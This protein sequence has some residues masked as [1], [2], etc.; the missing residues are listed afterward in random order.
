MVHGE[1]SPCTML[2]LLRQVTEVCAQNMMKKM[3]TYDS[4]ARTPNKQCH[5][6]TSSS[7][8]SDS[9]S[10][11]LHAPGGPCVPIREQ[12]P[13]SNQP[14]GNLSRTHNNL[15]CLHFWGIYTHTHTHMHVVVHQSKA[16]WSPP[17]CLL[18][19][20]WFATESVIWSKCGAWHGRCCLVESESSKSC[21]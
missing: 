13:E 10:P 16:P 17:P 6:P 7:R 3:L 2:A 8:M 4:P 18:I 12:L 9:P 21:R 5:T 20:V 15:Y 11:G 14:S 1:I 19:W